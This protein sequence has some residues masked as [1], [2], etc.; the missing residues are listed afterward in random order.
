MFHLLDGAVGCCSRADKL[1]AGGGTPRA[2]RTKRIRATA[3]DGTRERDSDDEVGCLAQSDFPYVPRPQQQP[4]RV[5]VRTRGTRSAAL[6]QPY[7]QQRTTPYL[8]AALYC[9]DTKRRRAGF[10]ASSCV[11]EPVSQPNH[12]FKRHHGTARRSPRADCLGCWWQS[13]GRYQGPALSRWMHS[14]T[15][16]ET[17][18]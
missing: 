15:T 17:F 16:L 6:P 8:V 12:V 2:I 7:E 14:V 13:F 9:L 5:H 1:G 4:N 18:L 10:P 11:P 3:A